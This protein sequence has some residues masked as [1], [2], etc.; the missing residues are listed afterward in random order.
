M[1]TTGPMSR[2]A[3]GSRE[4]CLRLSATAG[5]YLSQRSISDDEVM[6]PLSGQQ[7]VQITKLVP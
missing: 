6:S 5:T 7:E 2:K 1:T 3:F 4:T